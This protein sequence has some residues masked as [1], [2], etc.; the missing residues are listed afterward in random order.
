MTRTGAAP[1]AAASGCP[2][3]PSPGWRRSSP[4]RPPARAP[5]AAPASRRTDSRA[6][7]SIRQAAIS[8]DRSSPTRSLAE[9]GDR[10]SEQPAQLL[11]RHR[12]D[13]VL[14]EVHL[15]QFGE[16][17]RPRH[18]PLAPQPLQRAFQSHRRVRL[19]G[20]PATLH[21]LRAS[22]AEPIAVRPQRLSVPTRSLQLDQLTLLRHRAH[23]LV[24]TRRS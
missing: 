12:L 6:R 1:C 16:G 15:D 18:A 13:V 22:A 4:R 19:G 8:S 7:A 20:E 3:P 9:R 23:P 24:E 2:R 21:S 10:L 11:D 14:R 5:A 17:Q